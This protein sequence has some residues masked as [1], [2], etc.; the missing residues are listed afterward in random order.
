MLPA[1]ARVRLKG[2]PGVVGLVTSAPPVERANRIF[3]EVELP[4]GKRSYPANQLELAETAPDALVDLAAGKLSSPADLRRCLTHLRMTGRLAD[5]IYSMGATNT[6]FHAYQFKP[7]L[8]LLNSPSRGLLIAD[9]VGLGK[10]IEAGLVWTELVARFSCRRLLIVCPKALV[11]KWRDELRSKFNVDA[12]I[13]DASALIELLKDDQERREGFAAIAS[14]SSLRPPRGWNDPTENVEGARATLARLLADANDEERFDLVIF[15]EAH[16]LRNLE[17]MN[18]K[19]AQLLTSTAD[20]KLFLSATPINLRANDLRALLKLI[21][22]DIFERE[23]LFDVLQTENAPLVEAW[24]AARNPKVTL[25]ALKEL[26]DEL[27][28]GQVLKTGERLK[29]LRAE[30]EA[31]PPD[32]PETRVRLAARLEEMSLL[33]SIVNRTRRRDVVEFRVERRPQTARW[34]MSPVERQ[35][36][37]AAT[38]RIEQYAWERDLNER[39][40][41]AQSQRLLASSLPAAF[42]HWGERSGLLSLDEEEEGPQATPGPLVGALGD[43]CTDADILRELE[44]SD[45]KVKRLV[46]VLERLAEHDANQKIIIFS[47]FR[48]TIDYLARRLAEAGYQALQLHGG[49]AESRQDTV[50]RFADAAGG[51][52]LLTSEV[53][54]EGLDLQFCRTLI[55]FDLPWNPMKVEQR[56]GRIDRIGQ[57]SPTIDIVNLIAEATI[58]EMVYERLYERLGIIRQTLGD[59]EPILGKMVR[60]IELMLADPSLTDEERERQLEQAAQVAESLKREAELLEREAPGLVAHGDSILQKVREANAPH[61]MLTPADLRDYLAGTLVGAFDGTRFEPIPGISIEA[62]DVRLS[63]RAQAEFTRFRESNGRRYSTKFARDA[64]TGVQVAFGRNPD[65]LR[66][67]HIEPVPMTHPLAR[68]AAHTRNERLSGIAP[69]PATAFIV[70]QSAD[71]KMAP[72]RYVVAIEKWSIDAVLPVDRLAFSGAPISN[73][74]IL[75]DDLVERIL[76]EGLA[77]EPRMIQLTPED[78][79]L[80]RKALDER[81]LPALR[82]VRT[83]FEQ[84]EAARHYDLAE[85]QRALIVEHSARRQREAEGRIRELRLAG[86]DGRMRV[87]HLEKA[88]LDKFLARMEV[89]LDD[90]RKREN[91]FHL[92]EPILVGVAVVDV[93]GIA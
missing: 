33:G 62:Y 51:T 59:F 61:K 30:L 4:T 86:G 91:G 17:T 40:L 22:P 74:N 71:W 41:L 38:A 63:P 28:E 89:K 43:V 14:L 46:S 52:I 90:I 48:R 49:I 79:A 20:Y 34:Q 32:T 55:N 68:F 76:M 75:D 93:V 12:R 82:A 11:D 80:V 19:L 81:V 39:F 26:V 60:D 6:D 5:M 21:D 45:T 7:V 72:G 25:E 50:T 57:A 65:P 31:G 1:G 84:A 66:H 24:E 29:R 23:W 56:I 64:A 15:D 42:R 44:L 36:Y 87:A 88:K 85:T 9:E 54:G 53:G 83:D 16:H 70:A 13:C 73:G 78:L 18:H 27:P 92:E 58:E 37:D 69:R 8:K 47:S 2:D 67:R 77:R 3:I 35:F 10:T